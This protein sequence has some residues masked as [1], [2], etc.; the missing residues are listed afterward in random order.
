MENL[1]SGGVKMEMSQYI[2]TGDVSLGW[3][4][5]GLTFLLIHDKSL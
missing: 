5:P 3:L 4:P 2:N 1:H